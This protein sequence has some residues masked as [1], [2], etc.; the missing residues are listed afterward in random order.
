MNVKLL[1][2]KGR[3]SVSPHPFTSCI[4]SPLCS[5]AGTEDRRVTRRTSSG[6]AL[7]LRL[8]FL[9]EKSGEI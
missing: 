1:L 6:S 7:T 4:S 3:L 8:N 5:H 9:S 2:G